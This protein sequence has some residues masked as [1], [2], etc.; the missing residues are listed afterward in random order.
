[1]SREQRKWAPYS[2]DGIP[3][4]GI[5][6]SSAEDL[7]LAYEWIFLGEVDTCLTW[8]EGCHGSR[9]WKRRTKEMYDFKEVDI[10]GSTGHRDLFYGISSLKV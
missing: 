9:F 5:L 6:E 10:E 7:Y 1:M 4:V 3:R 8:F 2:V